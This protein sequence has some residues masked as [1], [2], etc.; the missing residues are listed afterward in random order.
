[1]KKVL[2]LCLIALFSILTLGSGTEV[3]IKTKYSDETI[4]GADFSSGNFSYQLSKKIKESPN[5][6]EAW[7]RLGDLAKNEMGGVIFSNYEKYNYSSVKLEIDSNRNVS[8][9]WNGGQ[10]VV[11]F[12]EYVLPCDQWT[13]IGV[14]RDE[15]NYSFSLYANGKLVQKVNT[16]TGMDAISNYSYIIGGDWS[17]W[18]VVKHPFQGEIGQV[19]V[20][21]RAL[22]S[23]D[24]YRDYLFSETISST[25]REGLLFNGELSFMCEE[26]I[27]TSKNNNDAKLRSNDYFYEGNLYEADDY[28]IAVIPDPQIMTHWRQQSLPSINNYL[29]NYNNQNANKLAMTICVG[30]NA[31]GYNA[32]FPEYTLDYQFSAMK[33]VY[34]ELY[35]QGIKWVTTPGNH[36]Y[37]DNATKTRDLSYYN[38][39]FSYDEISNYDYFL[40]SYKEDQTQ[41]AAYTFEAG[42]V[43]YLVI[44]IEFGS[45]DLVLNWANELV[46]NNPDKRVI[47]FTHAYIGGDG[48]IIDNNNPNSATKYGFANYVDTN[49][50]I[51]VFEKFISQHE[52]IFM[53]LSG[54][55]PSDD[56]LLKVS[57]G[58]KGNKIMQFLIDAQGALGGGAESLVS[59]MTFDEKNQTV[60]INYVNTMTNKLYNTQN[61]FTYSFK[62]HTKVLSNIYYDQNGN[63]KADY[64]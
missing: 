42:G 51:E 2:N 12:E 54:H 30:D 40:E 18:Q 38:K 6:I 14:V 41:N 13:H 20:Y 44:S 57:E 11:I 22:S 23:K 8:F 63:L 21:N 19:S 58:K 32:D 33:K 25:N 64:Q 35:E 27:D 50:P 16:Y 28:S 26:V 48:E 53:V 3:N 5:T 17:N 52:N 29:I 60:S 45:D 31:D 55:V 56:I 9:T 4:I 1:M 15:D 34:S 46:E 7:V 39:Y 37:D 49:S 61:Q 62:G 59:M 36:D 24:V 47:V 10:I 43:P